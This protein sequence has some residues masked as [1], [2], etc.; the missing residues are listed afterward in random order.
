MDLDKTLEE[1]SDLM[2]GPEFKPKE[3]LEKFRSIHAELNEHK[4]DLDQAIKAVENIIRITEIA[5]EVL[6]EVKPCQDTH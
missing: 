5:A 1:V 2:N 4:D 6:E 3:L